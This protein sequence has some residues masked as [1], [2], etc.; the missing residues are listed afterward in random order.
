MIRESIRMQGVHMDK[1]ERIRAS[2]R[3][4]V[5][6]ETIDELASGQLMDAPMTDPGQKQI[7][8]ELSRAIVALQVAA[9][10]LEA[11]GL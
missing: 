4:R 3:V 5:L 8:R 7:V 6:I 2:V 9:Q 11:E 10:A 1:Q